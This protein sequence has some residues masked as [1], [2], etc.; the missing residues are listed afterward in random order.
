MNLSCSWDLFWAFPWACAVTFWFS[1]YIQLFFN[2]LAFKVW[3]LKREKKKNVEGT[4]GLLDL[5]QRWTGWQQWGQCS[6]SGC[7]PFCLHLFDQ[8]QQW[9]V[10]A[11][12]PTISR[13]G[14]FLPALVSTS[15]S[16]KEH[17]EQMHGCLP[18]P[19][20]QEDGIAAPVLNWSCPKVNAIYHL[21]LLKVTEFGVLQSSKRVSSD[22]FCQCDCCLD[23]ETNSWCLLQIPPP[24]KLP[25]N[26]LPFRSWKK[27]H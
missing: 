17:T 11:Q 4:W 19:W 18:G 10:R 12:I 27:L 5:F 6:N 7:L 24:L 16:S 2:V 25:L 14:S 21:S 20:G 1:L 26:S 3:L 15:W 9:A 22:R 23:G 13:R 8:K